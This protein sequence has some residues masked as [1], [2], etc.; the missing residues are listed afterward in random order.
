MFFVLAPPCYSRAPISLAWAKQK[1]KNKDEKAIG[2][3]GTEVPRPFGRWVHVSC[4]VAILEARFVN[5]AER[6]P[7]DVS[8]IPLPRFRLVRREM[9]M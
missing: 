7:V 3:G 6:S 5:I 8:K 2:A 1:T 4:A 9:G